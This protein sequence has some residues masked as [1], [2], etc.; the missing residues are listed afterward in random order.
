[1]ATL[2]SHQTNQTVAQVSNSLQDHWAADKTF[3][4]R[5]VVFEQLAPII[6]ASL[7]D[8]FGVH[9]VHKHDDIADNEAVVH[10]GRV[11]QPE[12]IKGELFPIKWT[13]DGQVYEFADEAAP[14]VDKQVLNSIK[15]VIPPKNQVGLFYLTS[16]LREPFLHEVIV[17]GK[18][19]HEPMTE[20]D[21]INGDKL[22]TA[23]CRVQHE[24]RTVGYHLSRV[25]G[26]N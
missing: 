15:D 11:A 2:E 17:P 22:E 18:S 24:W 3:T 14:A 16:D 8:Y 13:R 10:H 6:D 19:T 5:E 20:D 1:M 7:G 25:G 26:S 12:P 4:D 21:K 9:L 23:W